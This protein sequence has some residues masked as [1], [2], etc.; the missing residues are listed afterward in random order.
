[1]A[2]SAAKDGTARPLKLRAEDEEDVGVISAILQD[3]MV[4]VGDM[5]YVGEDGRFVLLAS[6]LCRES[7]TAALERVRC[8][9]WFDEVKTVWR[10]HFSLRD[11]ERILVLLAIRYDGGNALRIDFSGG[12]GIRLE[13]GRILCHL[14]DIGEPWPTRQA[15]RHPV[16]GGA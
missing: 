16:E 10:Q 13:V 14:H 7:G 6:R 9:V 8:G 12:A 4:A 1:M 15:P 11:A 2:A 3:A 5:A